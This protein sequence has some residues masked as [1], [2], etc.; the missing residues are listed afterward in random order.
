MSAATLTRTTP[1]LFEDSDGYRPSTGTGTSVPHSWRWA[2]MHIARRASADPR[3]DASWKVLGNGFFWVASALAQHANPDG[4]NIIVSTLTLAEIGQC[5][6]D[7]VVKYRRA[8]IA[9]GLLVQVKKARGGLHPAP[10]VYALTMPLGGPDAVDPQIIVD[11]LRNDRRIRHAAAAR[12]NPSRDGVSIPGQNP[13]RD[14]IPDTRPAPHNPSPDTGTT[15]HVTPQDPSRDGT[16]RG[17]QVAYHERADVEGTGTTPRELTP[18]QT[19]DPAAKQP[20][21]D[22]RPVPAAYARAMAETPRRKPTRAPAGPAGTHPSP[23]RPQAPARPPA[24]VSQPC[25]VPDLPDLPH[26]GIPASPHVRQLWAEA[27]ANNRAAVERNRR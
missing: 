6:E 22:T 19:E 20:E 17:H 15:R 7:S 13:S 12:Q 16:T 3:R 9:A 2:I 24:R 23:S 11:E 14:S 25:P 4:G 8:L 10:A 1:S 5:S 26:S 21:P 27:R 18:E